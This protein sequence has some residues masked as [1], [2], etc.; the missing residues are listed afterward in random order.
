MCIYIYIY[1]TNIKKV[2][3]ETSNMKPKLKRLGY[4]LFQDTVICFSLCY[5]GT[6]LIPRIR[7]YIYIYTFTIQSP[8]R[9]HLVPAGGLPSGST[10]GF[11][12]VVGLPRGAP[13][14]PG[15]GSAGDASTNPPGDIQKV[16]KEKPPRKVAET[17]AKDCN[18]KV[19]D[20]RQ[21]ISKIEL[22]ET[23]WPGYTRYYFPH[24]V[25]ESKSCQS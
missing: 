14:G 24:G 7:E 9:S 11:G 8:P 20:A 25:R 18:S 3:P 12:A 2:V 1:I 4:P 21:L 15:N 16:K 22:N 19:A 17:K 10:P 5:L 13:P 23:L 6:P